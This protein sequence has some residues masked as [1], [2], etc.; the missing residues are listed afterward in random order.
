MAAPRVSPSRVATEL[1]NLD[2][3]FVYGHG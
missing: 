1:G 3:E 2:V